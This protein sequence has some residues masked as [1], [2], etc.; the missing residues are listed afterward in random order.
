MSQK[1]DEATRDVATKDEIRAAITQLC[2]KDDE[3]LALKHYARERIRRYRLNSTF[4]DPDDLLQTAV[5]KLLVGKRTW[6]KGIS[7]QQCMFGAIKSESYHQYTREKKF[8]QAIRLETQSLQE[9]LA[10]DQ[11]PSNEALSVTVKSAERDVADR[12]HLEA[13]A[14]ALADDDEALRVLACFVEMGGPGTKSELGITQNQLETVLVRIRR[15][16]RRKGID[17]GY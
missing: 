12:D 7:F 6:P 15:K 5:N 11:G 10:D 17:Y 14:A 4:T 13:I 9:T 3:L 16:L 8:N 2:K 1:Q